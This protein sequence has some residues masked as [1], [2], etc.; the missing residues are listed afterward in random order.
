[1]CGAVLDVEEKALEEAPRRRLRIP[2]RGILASIVT[3]AAFVGALGWVVREQIREQSRTPTPSPTLTA[4]LWPSR[5][6]TPVET[7]TPT[8][9]PTAMPPRAHMVQQNETCISIASDYG[10]SLELIQ[11]LNPEKCAPG[12]ILHPGDPLLLPAATPTAGPTP[13]HG[14]GTVVPT[15]ECPIL[16][17]VQAGE[18]ALGIAEMYP[19]I[20]LQLLEQANG[21][22]DLSNL[23]VNQV[24]QIPCLDPT[25]TPTPTP[26]PNATPT[27]VPKYAAPA[28][29]SPPDGATLTASLVPLQW[30]TVSLLGENEVYVVRLRRLDQEMPVE[31]IYVRETLVR[32]DE[33]YA[34]T[35]DDPLREYSWEVTVVREA[36]LNR[37]GE[38][39]YT[40]ASFPSVRRTF[41]WL[42]PDVEITP[43]ASSTP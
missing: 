19:G 40:A 8:L 22:E 39:R 33:A 30:T 13:T 1:M 38:L 23:Q 6:P 15:P 31:S 10:I 9:T 21:G 42:V 34:P 26:D 17:V 43:G 25:A 27:P 18:T 2:W 16:H 29:L 7:P 12:A 4:T 14:P 11:S 35:P 3:V 37:S 24:L 20:S 32:L 28:L 5:T 36:G 41:R